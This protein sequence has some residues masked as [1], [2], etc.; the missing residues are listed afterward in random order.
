MPKTQSYRWKGKIVTKA[1]YE[2]RLA[3]RK[4]GQMRRKGSIEPE[5]GD[6]VTNETVDSVDDVEQQTNVIDGRRIIDL[7][8]LG[9]QLWCCSCGEVLSLQYIQN[10]VRRGLASLFLVLCHKCQVVNEVCTNTQRRTVDK[11]RVHFDIN[12]Q[13]AFGTLHSG[14]GWTRLKKLLTCMNIPCPDF[15]TFKK[16]EQEVRFA[17][18]EVAEESC[19]EANA[20]EIQL[21]EEAESAKKLL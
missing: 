6:P 15:K 5:E 7:N 19:V 14:L 8:V 4:A 18:E 2:K 9:Q 11:R 12:S 17:A 13:A 1:V 3:Q 20:L 21:N 10:E 16:Y